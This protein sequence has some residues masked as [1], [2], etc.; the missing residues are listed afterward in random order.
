MKSDLK[1][2]IVYLT[3][4]YTL[5]CAM[6]FV[7]YVFLLTDFFTRQANT[8]VFDAYKQEEAVYE[9][10][11]DTLYESDL[12]SNPTWAS[13][14]YV[15]ENLNLPD[16]LN[17]VLV[18]SL[19]DFFKDEVSTDI[20]IL[21]RKTSEDDTI[22]YKPI[23]EVLETR[24]ISLFNNYFMMHRGG[25]ILYSNHD[26]YGT[27][28]N[29]YLQ[30][31]NLYDALNKMVAANESNYVTTNRDGITEIISVGPIY[32]DLFLVNIAPQNQYISHFDPMIW[33]LFTFFVLSIGTMIS[34]NSVILR[35]NL[36]ED[37]LFMKMAKD[38]VD[39]VYLI[40][41]GGHGQI[42]FANYRFYEE[43]IGNKKINL[44]SELSKEPLDIPQILKR[45]KPFVLNIP[46][47]DETKMYRFI[48][49]RKTRGFL[50]VAED[51]NRIGN[52]GTGYRDLALRNQ[53][54]QL[55]NEFAMKESLTD[56]DVKD[57]I[58][59]AALQIFEFDQFEQTL[60]REYS[61]QLIKNTLNFLKKQLPKDGVEL[62]HALNNN[63]LLVYRNFG[64]PQQIEAHLKT[65]LDKVKSAV[66]L[67]DLPTQVILKAGLIH[68]AGKVLNSTLEE[69]YEHLMITLDRALKS[70]A[71]DLYVYDDRLSEY[72]TKQQL[73]EIDLQKAIETDE[74]M[75]YLQ[76]QYDLVQE[77]VVGYEAL[78]RWNNPKYIKES[79][80]VFIKMAE[81]SNL[82]ISLGRIIIKKVFEIV[83]KLEN[84]D[85]E[86]S[87]N[88]S[89][90]QLLQPGFVHDLMSLVKEYDV[91]PHMIGIEMTETVLVQSFDLI[92]EKLSTLKQQGFKIHLDDFGTGYSSLSYLKNL[93]VD[94]IKID[95]QFVED[96][97]NN[98]S[99]RTILRMMMSLGKALKLNVIYEG[100]E[101][102]KQAEL[103]K[104]DGGTVIQGFLISKPKPFEEAIKLLNKE[105]D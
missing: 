21:I 55:P 67:E 76:P 10:L 98:Q 4:L 58:A 91:K 1:K 8:L 53:E 84:F 71:Y 27:N 103:I 72:I 11:F 26:D 65:I 77:K 68:F 39:Y 88:I 51:V 20:V 31:N 97:E 25:R 90:R 38:Q 95:R 47:Y 14:P 59:V 30:Y 89:P 94:V 81:R 12:A 82:I 93:P 86:I 3:I 75:M 54:S 36:S 22:Y 85:L 34:F 32:G 40:E 50:L 46:Y 64:T 29:F 6:F 45:Q 9:E 96:I 87:F 99:A 48:P 17:K 101:T 78:L 44:I 16:L 66:L 83:K 105:G 80:A 13:K 100:V 69:V 15:L 63:F 79:P 92:I 28:L 35:K 52:V 57:K 19:K 42:R 41:V 73:M 61:R 33:S 23:T 43:V 74:F 56:I 7:F 24:G 104:K 18:I 49:I 102:Q 37:K 2:Y 5:I 60:G 62:F 70:T